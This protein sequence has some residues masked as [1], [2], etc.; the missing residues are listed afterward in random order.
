MFFKMKSNFK[1]QLNLKTNH[2]Q[3]TQWVIDGNLIKAN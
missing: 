2:T 1:M 3:M